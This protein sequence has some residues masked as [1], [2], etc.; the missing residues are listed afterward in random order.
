M[1]QSGVDF[2][3]PYSDR[4]FKPLIGIGQGLFSGT[5]DLESPFRFNW[6]MSS[7]IDLYT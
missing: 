1:Y 3:C 7:A 6:Y 5:W 2:K 4:Q